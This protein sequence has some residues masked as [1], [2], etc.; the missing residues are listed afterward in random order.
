MMRLAEVPAVTGRTG[1]EGRAG[2]Q[3]P[4]RRSKKNRYWRR[5]RRRSSV[6]A[7]SPRC[8]WSSSPCLRSA[9][10][11]ASN[12]MTSATSPS[13]ARTDFCG[14]SMNP[15]WISRHLVRR[16]SLSW[17]PSSGTVSGSCVDALRSPATASGCSPA[18]SVILLLG[19]AW[20]H[21]GLPSGHHLRVAATHRSGA[22]RCPRWTD[23]LRRVRHA[24]RSRV[25]LLAACPCTSMGGCSRSGCWALIGVRHPRKGCRCA[26]V[27]RTG[28]G[29]GPSRSAVLPSRCPCRR[30][31]R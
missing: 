18:S 27:P 12:W 13:A 26:A 24:R 23:P 8:H 14:S 17:G 1:R 11:V 10:V 6:A 29:S 20:R 25:V 9:K 28:P 30:R 15:C 3:V 21:G 7:S 4:S 2:G 31:A 16:A 5:A 22:G 19:A